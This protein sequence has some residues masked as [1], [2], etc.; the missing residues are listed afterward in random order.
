V[1]G[2]QEL[3]VEGREPSEAGFVERLRVDLRFGLG[4]K[5]VLVLPENRALRG[6]GFEAMAMEMMCEFTGELVEAVEVGVELIAAVI[7]AD[8]TAVAKLLEDTVDSVA[9]VVAP[10]VERVLNWDR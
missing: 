6:D 7:G 10:V 2:E 9:V 8:E 5:F 1:P 3:G 4:E